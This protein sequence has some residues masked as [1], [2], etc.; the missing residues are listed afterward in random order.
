MAKTPC[1]LDQSDATCQFIFARIVQD[2]SAGTDDYRQL[3]GIDMEAIDQRFRLPVV[4]GIEP[5][6]RGAITRQEPLE[7]EHLGIFGAARM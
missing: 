2:L 1:R 7:F 4:V 5:H 6:A 3:S